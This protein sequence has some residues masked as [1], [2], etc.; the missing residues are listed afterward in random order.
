MLGHGESVTGVPIEVI[1]RP[2]V[3]EAHTLI[4]DPRRIIEALGWQPA[5]SS[6]R[7]IIKDAWAAKIGSPSEGLIPDEFA[8]SLRQ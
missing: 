1:H 6:L 8:H 7:L 2:P 4:S 5:R 3:A